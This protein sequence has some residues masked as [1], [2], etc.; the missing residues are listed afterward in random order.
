MASTGGP[1]ACTASAS[2]PTPGGCRR[3]PPGRCAAGIQEDF[4]R[5]SLQA[6]LPLPTRG[7][8]PAENSNRDSSS[9]AC[10]LGSFDRAVR[11]STARGRK[12]RLPA[13]VITRNG[14][15]GFRLQAV[16]RVER[17]R[18]FD[19]AADARAAGH[20]S[21]GIILKLCATSVLRTCRNRPVLTRNRMSK[22]LIHIARLSFAMTRSRVRS[23]SAPPF[24][25]LFI[26]FFA[27]DGR[28]VFFRCATFVLT[29][30]AAAAK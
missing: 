11:W 12:C 26:A 7:A 29:F 21:C 19:P 23:P 25:R 28:R 27:R 20:T 4:S 18:W 16:T 10:S 1:A 5:A 15:H 14:V 2:W 22:C 30:S 13:G 17:M 8:H 6:R 24:S 3:L 9:P